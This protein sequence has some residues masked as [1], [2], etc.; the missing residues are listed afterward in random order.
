M[1]EHLTTLGGLISALGNVQSVTVLKE[2]LALIQDRLALAEKEGV[3][4]AAENQRLTQELDA[5]KRQLAAHAKTKEFVEHRGAFFR[6]DAT[7]G[8]QAVVYCPECERATA[9][10]PEGEPFTCM[11][12]GW[13]SAFH[14]A[15]LPGILSSIPR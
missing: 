7:G 13:I 14:E 12:C 6:R 15:Q 8:Y 2:R 5:A 4:L 1:L 3:S 11:K 10:W 9:A